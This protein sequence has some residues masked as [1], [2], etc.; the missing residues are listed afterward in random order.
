MGQRSE[1]WKI[2]KTVSGSS[3]QRRKLE[4]GEHNH[5]EVSLRRGISRG[6][7]FDIVVCMDSGK[8]STMDRTRI[9]TRERKTDQARSI[10]DVQKPHTSGPPHGRSDNKLMQGTI[11]VHTHICQGQGILE[12][13]SQEDEAVEGPST[14]RITCRRRCMHTIY[15]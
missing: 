6:K 9:E 12:N 1:A 2:T 8:T 3:T 5:R 4:D 14:V 7:T 13:K 15:H 11:L 10:R